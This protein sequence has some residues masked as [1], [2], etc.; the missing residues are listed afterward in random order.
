MVFDLSQFSV[1]TWLENCPQGY[2][3]DTEF[4]H[5]RGEKEPDRVLQDPH[6]LASAISTTVQL[7]VAE[8]CALAA[9]SGLINLTPDEQSK[10][11]LATQT[12]DEA[13]H[14]EIFSRRLG[15]LG[16]S[17]SELN[18]TI[19][20]YANPNLLKFAE[21]LLE[22]VH[23]GDL[24]AAIVGQNII[25]EGLA[26]TVFGMLRAMARRTNP[27][28][29]HTLQGTIADERRHVS[30]GENRIRAILKAQPDK[31]PVIQKLQ[32]EMSY[33]ML[34]S[35]GDLFGGAAAEQSLGTLGGDEDPSEL[36]ASW[37]GAN[38]AALNATELRELL[39]GTLVSELESRLGR[40]GL[41]YQSSAAGA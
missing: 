9:S 33:F 23:K 10:C 12:L 37:Q 3:R 40:L 6:L 34:A 30:F 19:R 38:L 28:F 7:V 13:R 4:G 18:A 41:E 29:A 1:Q 31:K 5:R 14:V 20:E 8:R 11:F 24:A 32:R 15:D 36:S 22:K 26:Y 35:F 27:K 17:R 21:V 2:L 16:V 39:K 25:L